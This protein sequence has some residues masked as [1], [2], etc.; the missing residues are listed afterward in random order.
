MC[1][2]ILLARTILIIVPVRVPLGV[3]FILITTEFGL[4]I[5]ATE[6]LEYLFRYEAR[7]YELEQAIQDFQK[8]QAYNGQ[9]FPEEGGSEH[10]KHQACQSSP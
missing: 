5:G 6:A 3:E 10:N 7:I 2:L 8:L 1:L 4:L 9:T